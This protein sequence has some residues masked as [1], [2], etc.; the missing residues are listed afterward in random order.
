MVYC[1]YIGS[2]HILN[3]LHKLVRAHLFN[4]LFRLHWHNGCYSSWKFSEWVGWL[5]ISIHKSVPFHLAQK[6]IGWSSFATQHNHA[7]PLFYVFVVLFC[8][9]SLFSTPL[10]VYFSFLFGLRRC[11]NFA[12]QLNAY[13]KCEIFTYVFHISCLIIRNVTLNAI[14]PTRKRRDNNNNTLLHSIWAHLLKSCQNVS[15]PI[16]I[17]SYY[18]NDTPN[19]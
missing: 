13:L 9:I 10:R 19:W 17:S 4:S 2:K 12:A 1:Y 15:T 3:V 18:K 14:S 11:T 6:H 8:F 5:L 16:A 7:P